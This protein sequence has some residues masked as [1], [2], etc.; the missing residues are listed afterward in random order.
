MRSSGADFEGG[1]D[2]VVLVRLSWSVCPGEY[3]T[4]KE[5]RMEAG[6]R[7]MLEQIAGRKLLVFGGRRADLISFGA[8]KPWVARCK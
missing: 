1:Q 5:A 2:A 7:L 8:K 6:H 3:Q 4:G